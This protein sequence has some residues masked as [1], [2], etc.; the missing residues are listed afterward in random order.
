LFVKPGSILL[1]SEWKE[2]VSVSV[3]EVAGS[4][5]AECSGPSSGMV[6]WLNDLLECDLW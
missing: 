1:V 6:G 2:G 5:S 4:Q 3:E